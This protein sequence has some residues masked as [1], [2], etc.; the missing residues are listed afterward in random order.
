MVRQRA[1]A[2]EGRFTRTSSGPLFRW[3]HATSVEQ[4][5]WL[6]EFLYGRVWRYRWFARASKRVIGACSGRTLG[7]VIDSAAPDL[8]LSTYP[9]ASTA[10]EW[11]RH[12][13]GL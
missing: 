2:L 13:R 6:Y 5:L 9:M 7:P 8:V 11:L 10:L 3:I 4:L 12:H 1:A